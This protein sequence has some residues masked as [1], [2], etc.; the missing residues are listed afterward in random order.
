MLKTDDSGEIGASRRRLRT[1]WDRT[2][3]PPIR[4]TPPPP[5]AM[6]R[7]LFG[8][9]IGAAMRPEIQTTVDE[10]KQALSLLRRHL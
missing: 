7:A 1:A 8:I 2:A 6:V 4:F 9:T 10:I 5:V 3:A